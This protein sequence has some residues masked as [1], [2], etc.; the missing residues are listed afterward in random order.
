MI[1]TIAIIL[2][3]VFAFLLLCFVGWLWGSYNLFVTGKQNIKTMWSNIKTEYQR[4]ADMFYNLAE[5]VKGYA[6][7]EK[8]TMT[9]VIA[10]RNGNFGTGKAAELKNM[11]N[12]DNFFARLLAVFEAYPKLRAVEE[13][14]RLMVNIRVTEDRVNVARVEYNDV[15]RDYNLSVNTFPNNL[16]ANKFGFKE[17]AFFENEAGTEKAPKLDLSFK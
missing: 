17:E 4:R 2:T 3:S 9:Q 8:D 11:K 10:M 15:V 13:Y 6:K 12:L 7:F 5:T 16:I 1:G 14:D